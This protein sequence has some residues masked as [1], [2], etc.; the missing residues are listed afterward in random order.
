MGGEALRTA[1]GYKTPPQPLPTRGRGY[2]AAL[3]RNDVTAIASVRGRN[4]G[5][6]AGKPS[7]LWGGLGGVFSLSTASLQED[8]P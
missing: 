5:G 2:G 6:A 7:P 1:L 3:L 8:L 4:K